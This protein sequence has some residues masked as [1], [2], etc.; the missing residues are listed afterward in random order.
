MLL[1]SEFLDL[2]N[3]V[4]ET[5][6]RDM[7]VG[8]YYEDAIR[9]LSSLSLTTVLLVLLVVLVTLYFW[10]VWDRHK[11]PPAPIPWPWIGDLPTALLNYKNQGEYFYGKFRPNIIENLH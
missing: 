2:Y 11:Y 10:P 9:Y 3:S 7:D 4:E 5:P 1:W 6:D 8:V